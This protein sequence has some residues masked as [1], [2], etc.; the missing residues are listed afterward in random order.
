MDNWVNRLGNERVDCK[1]INP[2]TSSTKHNK[3]L[4]TILWLT[5]FQHVTFRY[6]N[7]I[8]TAGNSIVITVLATLRR[9]SNILICLF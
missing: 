8:Q 2:T 4:N 1:N 5:I 9:I 6:S 7:K 3:K